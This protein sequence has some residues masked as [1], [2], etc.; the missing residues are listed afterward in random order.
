MDNI[1]FGNIIAAV[2]IAA[3]ALLIAAGIAHRLGLL[4]ADPQEITDDILESVKESTETA[5]KVNESLE[6]TV[7]DVKQIAGEVKKNAEEMRKTLSDK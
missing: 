3:F 5:R 6:T 4:K 7:R 1:D 2:A